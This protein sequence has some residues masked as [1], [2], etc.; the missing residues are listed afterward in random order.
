[1]PPVYLLKNDKYATVVCACSNCV[2]SNIVFTLDPTEIPA[3]FDRSLLSMKLS[4]GI[5]SAE[6]NKVT[7]NLTEADAGS[8]VFMK[9]F[10]HS[11]SK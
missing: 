6:R 9:Y 5:F 7:I 4:G 3:G 10:L 8:Y 2:L 11:L 1:M